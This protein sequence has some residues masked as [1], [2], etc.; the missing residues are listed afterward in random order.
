MVPSNSSAPGS[1][2]YGANMGLNWCW[3]DPSRPH[4][5]ST[6]LT[7]WCLIHDIMLNK[8]VVL[9]LRLVRRPSLSNVMR[10]AA[11]H[12]IKPPNSLVKSIPEGLFFYVASFCWVFMAATW[13]MLSRNWLKDMWEPV[14]AKNVVVQMMSSHAYSTLRVHFLTQYPG[15]DWSHIAH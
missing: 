6:N 1:K 7:I 11:L 2:V 8:G 9:Q 5:G 12:Q 10:S 14:Y 13:Y 15:W 4:V 3:Q